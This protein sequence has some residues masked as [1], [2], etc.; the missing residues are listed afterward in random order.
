[1]E[2][3][4][5]KKS[6]LWRGLK[7]TLGLILLPLGIVGLF[8]PVLQG[9]LFLLLALALLSS[10]VPFFERIRDR[11]RTRYPGPWDKA[12]H[13]GERAKRWFEVKV[14]RKRAED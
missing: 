3:V 11:I 14:L 6:R 9:I 12:H 7:I 1:M 5:E 8:V 4:V 13:L 2:R 10:E